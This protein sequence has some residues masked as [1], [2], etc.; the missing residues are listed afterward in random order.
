VPLAV[1]LLAGLGAISTAIIF[2]ASAQAAPGGP[3]WLHYALIVA[4]C[5]ATALTTWA[6][7][8]AAIPMS[9]FLGKTGINVM[10]RLMGLLLAAVA[11][12]IFVGGVR[13]LMTG[14]APS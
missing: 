10:V 6:T 8:R 11:V 4:C 14:L 2:G 7:L 5:L 9:H 3:V 12:E 13:G 1:P